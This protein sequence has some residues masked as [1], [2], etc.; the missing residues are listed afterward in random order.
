MARGHP[1]SAS[2]VARCAGVDPARRSKWASGGNPLVRPGPGFTEHDAVETAVLAAL[3]RANQKLARD[4]WLAVRREL[5]TLVL[6][7]GSDIWLLL[8]M[9]G[10]GHGVT[11]SAATAAEFAAESAEPYRVLRVGDQIAEARHR[12]AR[13]VAKLARQSTTGIAG[14]RRAR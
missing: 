8:S 7:G 12:F 13:E 1:I 2:A 14:V 10:H 11:A 9:S 4:A 6:A 3:A 5:R